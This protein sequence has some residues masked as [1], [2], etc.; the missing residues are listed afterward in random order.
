MKQN[1]LKKEY[2][3]FKEMLLETST[4]TFSQI[5]LGTDFK[6]SRVVEFTKKKEG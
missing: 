6:S 3:K 4:S 1:S 2:D 5:P